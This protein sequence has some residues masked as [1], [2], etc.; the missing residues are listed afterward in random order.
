[1][2]VVSKSHNHIGEDVK[3]RKKSHFLL[4]GVQI[5]T[6]IVEISLEISQKLKIE[7]P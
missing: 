6:A 3:K 2:A 5:T 4:V 1:M 7:L